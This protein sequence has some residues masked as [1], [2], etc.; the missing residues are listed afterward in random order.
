MAIHIQWL[1]TDSTTKEREFMA[2]NIHNQYAWI[3]WVLQDKSLI[4]I[5]GR[6]IDCCNDSKIFGV[7]Y[8][9]PNFRTTAEFETF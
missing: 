6:K 2:L 4:S 9:P 5:E 3:Q 7:G 8:E 1:N